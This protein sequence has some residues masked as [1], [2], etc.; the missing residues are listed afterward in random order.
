MLLLAAN[1]LT[2]GG[3]LGQITP[4]A[5]WSLGEESG[6]VAADAI[7]GLDGAHHWGYAVNQDGA[8]AADGAV[9]YEVGGRVGLTT[10]Q[11]SDLLLLNEGTLAFSMFSTDS[12]DYE[13]LISKDARGYEE[14]GHMS[15]WTSNVTQ[16]LHIGLADTQRYHVVRTGALQADRWY[17]VVLSW[18]AGG[19][20]L[21]LD[22]ALVDT[23]AFAGGLASHEPLVFGASTRWS[24]VGVADPYCDFYSGLLDE[25]AIYNQ[26]LNPT[27]VQNSLRILRTVPLPA[28]SGLAFAGAVTV[29]GTLRRR[30]F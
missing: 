7:S 19:M 14:A 2:A 28:A 1:G 18:G 12:I 10:V 3:T 24:N 16:G 8:Q 20:H 27:Q 13:G 17:D 25:I 22:G 11:H 30:Q 9:R 26:A 29:F 15:A 4:V 21:Y 6:S 5:Y 23:D